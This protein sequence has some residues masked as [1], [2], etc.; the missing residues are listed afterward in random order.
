MSEI[1]PSDDLWYK[2]TFDFL[3]VNLQLANVPFP[4]IGS[5]NDI[6]D[7]E[8]QLP[9][10]ESQLKNYTD[11]DKKQMIAASK[12]FMKDDFGLK[13]LEMLGQIRGGIYRWIYIEPKF[14]KSDQEKISKHID[15]YIDS[16]LNNELFVYDRNYLTFEKQKQVFIE[17]VRSMS[18]FEKYGEN[19]IISH[20]EHDNV[21]KNTGFLFTHTLY[22]LKKLKY[23][24]VLRIWCGRDNLNNKKKY[25]ANIVANDSFIDEV[26]SSFQKENP[27]TIFEG[28]DKT[29]NIIKF[30]GKEIELSKKNKE[31]D[32]VLLIKS[33][34]KEPE[35]YW[36]NDELLEDWG[37]R[38]QDEAAKNKTYFAARKVNDAVK[39]K[40]GIDDFIDHNTSKFRINPKYLKVD[41]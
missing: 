4:K 36:H 21:S 11:E 13:E 20:E 1:V 32:A 23:V 16:F 30:A 38:S 10:S 41:E 34:I 18:A 3:T 35:R 33:L 24:T 37:Y 40:T 8:L 7:E 6:P 2:E 19:F 15:N 28:Y 27:S 17:K 25:Y 29:H 9:P 14:E 22:A 31:T 39:M 12:K 26:N 5:Y